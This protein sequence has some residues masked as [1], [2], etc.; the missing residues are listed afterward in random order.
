[1]YNSTEPL[2][3]TKKQ[4]QGVSGEKQGACGVLSKMSSAPI[5]I[6]VN[7]VSITFTPQKQDTVT[8]VT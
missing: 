4:I 7:Q 6:I 5:N 8:I 1:M 3:R 2:K